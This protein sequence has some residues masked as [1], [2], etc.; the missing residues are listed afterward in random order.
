[1]D[2]ITIL[3]QN[4]LFWETR[5]T[6]LIKVY[7]NLIPDTIILNSHGVREGNN[8]KI[9]GYSAYLINTNNE[10][11]DGSAILIKEGIKHRVDD[12]FHTD[13]IS[14]QIETSLGPINISTTYLLPRRPYL[15]F[16]DFHKLLYSNEPMYILGDLN[17]KH[18]FL[19]DRTNNDVG[20]GLNRFYENK[21]LLHLG[22]KFPT[23]FNHTSGTTPDLIL[24]NN[25]IYHNTKIE[26]GPLTSSDH[27]PILF[28]ITAR[29][30]TETT[31]RIIVY[32]KTNW[33]LFR[34]VV[35]RNIP[36]NENW[37]SYEGI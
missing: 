14:L 11:H 13:V 27:L 37:S 28:T 25:K 18:S 32:S 12:S 26:P 29:A 15:P 8:I 9:I 5:K 16:P 23:F 19:I 30:I 34:E 3:Q 1:M 10:M 21:I 36:E 24:S 6:E 4:V 7:R 22:P 17:A 31:P 20:K 33:D 2:T 35:E